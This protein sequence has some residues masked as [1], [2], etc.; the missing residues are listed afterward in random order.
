MSMEYF[1]ILEILNFVSLP[2]PIFF[3]GQVSTRLDHFAVSPLSVHPLG[4]EAG[5]VGT[6][7]EEH[8]WW[9]FYTRMTRRNQT[10]K[11]MIA[12]FSK[13]KYRMAR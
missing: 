6:V 2:L 13:T 8:I 9:H 5:R 3:Q 1:L 10:Q 12:R 11:C 7:E 4:S